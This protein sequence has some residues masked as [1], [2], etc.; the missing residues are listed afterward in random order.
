MTRALREARKAVGRTRPNPLVGAVVVKGGR[1]LAVGHH[2]KAGTP[3]AEVVALARAG[4]RA[5]GA[6]LH[7]TLEPCCHQ[8][9][10]G[11]CTEA[12]L[13]AGVRRVVVGCRDRNPLVD[14]KGIARL[15]RAGVQVVSGCLED[16]CFAL[17]RAFFCWVSAHRPLVTLKF[18]ATLDGVIGDPTAAR[19]SI[20]WITGREARQE[21]HRLRA[22]HDAVLVGVGTILRDDPRLTVRGA[23][24]ARPL[25]VV[26]DTDLRTP[27]SARFLRTRDG[28]PRPL[29]V[30]AGPRKN[31][32]RRQRALESGGAEVL[33]LPPG[34][35][36]RPRLAGVLRALAGRDIQSLLVEGGGHVLGAFVSARL[37]D[38]VAVFLAPTLAGGG[39]RALEGPGLGLAQRLPLGPT[40][41]RRVGKDLLVT[42]DVVSSRKE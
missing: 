24:G 7:V 26:L 40:T 42:A 29:I 19:G 41:V 5:R 9:R 36:G 20:T 15:R 39:V 16:A 12:I 23:G 13:A 8:G 35:D 31:L 38:R 6:I 14:G 33:W 17:N 32:Q 4:K 18:A 1:V 11:P 34:R 22:R 27:P 10:T 28:G 25:R 21:A 37:V 3:H 30:A 2:K